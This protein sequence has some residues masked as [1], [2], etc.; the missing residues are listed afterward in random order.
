MAKGTIYVHFHDKESLFEELVRTS[1]SPLIASLEGAPLRELTLRSFAE[2]LASIFV[3]EIFATRRKDVLRLII[4]EGQRFPQLAH[5]YYREV[6]KRAMA[7]VR[8]LARQARERGEIRS[9]A[10]ERFPQLLV[11]PAIMAIIWDALFSRFEPIEVAGLMQQ[12]VALLLK[13]L[14][15]PSG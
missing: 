6:V 13:A 14:E 4:A 12:H 7:V 2:Q 1:L 10:L 11:S 8:S 9:N 5:I 3:N 15:E